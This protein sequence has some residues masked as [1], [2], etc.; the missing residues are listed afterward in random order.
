MLDPLSMHFA[1]SHMI[2]ETLN[3]MYIACVALGPTPIYMILGTPPLP[4]TQYYGTQQP[5]FF[6]FQMISS[7]FQRLQQHTISLFIYNSLTQNDPLVNPTPHRVQKKK[8]KKTKSESQKLGERG[9]KGTKHSQ[10]HV[11]CMC[12]TVA[13]PPPNPRGLRNPN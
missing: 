4:Q 5:I 9:E 12:C 11:D 2:L 6:P 3:S 8:K 1:P 7:I 13:T 10:F